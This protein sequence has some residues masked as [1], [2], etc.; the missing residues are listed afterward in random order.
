MVSANN[1][2]TCPRCLQGAKEAAERERNEVSALYGHVAMEEFDRRRAE[3]KPVDESAYRT[4]RE[5]YHIGAYE[6]H[7]EWEY[8]GSCT[9]CGLKAKT[10][11]SKLFWD[12][13][14]ME[15]VS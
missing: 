1:W 12:S 10:E 15:E 6:G 4:F 8:S 14:G 2:T 5:D 3:L 9:K 13:I 7:I 11:G